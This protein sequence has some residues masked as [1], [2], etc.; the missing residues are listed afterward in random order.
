MT[1]TTSI[2]GLFP[3][4]TQHEGLLAWVAK[5]AALTQP[6]RVH[7]CDGSDAEWNRLTAELVT[8][9]YDLR[10]LIE[11]IVTRPEYVEA[12]RFDVKE[13]GR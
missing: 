4:P 9:N 12:G 3:A 11:T 10:A 5:T 2:P 8:S 6:D 13:H 7:W 1:A